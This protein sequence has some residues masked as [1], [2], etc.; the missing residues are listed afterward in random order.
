MLKKQKRIQKSKAQLIEENRMKAEVN[1][2][3]PIAKDV[4]FASLAAYAK[5]ITHAQRSCEILKVVMQGKMNQYWT[6]KTVGDLG[7]VDELSK[8][9]KLTD[10]ELYLSLLTGFSDVRIVDAMKLVDGMCGSI[11][12]YL[13]K[14]AS[15]KPFSDIKVEE[16]I[17]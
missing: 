3:W 15:K 12:G 13:K 9:E 16:I 2:L 11:D 17:G 6:E 8:D 14:E 5:S 10:R 7:L 4:I 1:R